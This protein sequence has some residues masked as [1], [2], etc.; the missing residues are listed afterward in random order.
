MQ[1]NLMLAVLLFGIWFQPS[2][3]QAQPD[4]IVGDLQDLES[5]GSV[6]DIFA[7]SVGTTS[8][9]IG[10]QPLDW[11]ATTPAHPVIGQ[12]LYRY[13]D[14]IME[15]VGHSWLKHGF[16]ALSLDLCSPCSPTDCDTLGVGCSDP[17]TASRNGTQSNLGPRSDI[18]AW[19]GSFPYPYSSLPP[20]A[21][22]IGRR[23]QVERSAVD[24][25][26][27]PGARYFVE[28]HYVTND[29]ALA[30]NGENNVS[31]REV[32][33]GSNPSSYP[34]QFIPGVSTVREQPAIL[35]W[36]A[37]DSNVEVVEVRVPGEGLLYLASR[38]TPN[39]GGTWHYEYAL[40]NMNSDISA[41]SIQIPVQTGVTV[42]NPSFY[43][44][45]FHS[46][47]VYSTNPWTYLISTQG[48]EWATQTFAQNPNAN[49]LRWG[50]MFNVRFDANAAPESGTVTIQQFKQV[51]AITVNV[52]VPGD[53]I[54][55]VP[56]S[57]TCSS[58]GVGALIE[59]SNPYPYATIDVFRDGSVIA[60]LPGG[61]TSY[62]DTTVSTGLSYDYA[63]I[64]RDG[65][66]SSPAVSCS[67][68]IPV[69]VEFRRGDTNED[70]TSDVSDVVYY[71]ASL[72]IPG[73]PQPGCYDTCDANDDGVS[74][75]S[76]AVVMLY[77]LFLPG[78]DPLPAPGIS[79]GVDP[80]PDDLECD[81]FSSC[82]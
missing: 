22:T 6:G 23:L 7:Y 48:V 29:D 50:R 19:T 26:Q 34:L 67:V 54:L 30:G 38:I 3:A 53:P 62:F 9:N 51:G 82:P 44:R 49:A 69:P 65:A 46:N 14:G 21:A 78:S 68:D 70:G 81:D 66:A 74:D 77:A 12:Q 1:R 13:K 59:W 41:R 75:I 33:I 39:P 60:T 58:D 76:D 40:Y 45:P 61:S 55:P 18:D 43:G 20:A 2:P 8:C 71:L 72:F 42:S 27:N 15:Q 35:A 37:I 25:F 79:C 16:C 4:V 17:Y 10:N 56:T 24:P 64:G 32:S 28:G 11:Y 47:E 57:F 80:T 31:Y 63:V 5:W 36:A 73:A 52:D